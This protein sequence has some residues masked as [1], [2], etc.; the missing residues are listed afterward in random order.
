MRREGEWAGPASRGGHP[1]YW[2]VEDAGWS[3]P[4]LLVLHG[5]PGVPHDYLLPL[6]AL[7]RAGRS[8][9]FYD[10]LGCGGSAVEEGALDP[11]LFGEPR[12]VQLRPDDHLHRRRARV[13]W[14]RVS[15]DLDPD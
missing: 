9:V 15:R 2:R 5:G 11:A 3:K 4:P 8:V 10:Q 14:T 6:G 7:A 12:L 13:A 1:L